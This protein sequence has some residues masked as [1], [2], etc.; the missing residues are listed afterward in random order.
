[1][2]SRRNI[3]NEA[4]KPH[5]ELEAE[6]L[7]VLQLSLLRN[8]PLYKSK[9]AFVRDPFPASLRGLITAFPS[10]RVARTAAVARMEPVGSHASDLISSYL[11]HHNSSETTALFS[12]ATGTLGF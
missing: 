10:L 1:M 4:P 6:V 8:H 5:P 9:P 12:D 2:L 3:A 7:N 11:S